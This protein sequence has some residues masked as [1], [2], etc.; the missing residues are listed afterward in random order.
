MEEPGANS[1]GS[2]SKTLAADTVPGWLV[3][4]S[5]QEGQQYSFRSTPLCKLTSQDFFKIGIVIKSKIV[6][7]TT[8]QA[9][10]LE[11]RC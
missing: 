3:A 1:G 8:Q 7:L 4:L 2:D 11:M 6:L 5:T 10:K 9:N